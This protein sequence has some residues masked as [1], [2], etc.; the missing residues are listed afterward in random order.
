MHYGTNSGTYGLTE[1]FDHAHYLRVL[2]ARRCAGLP[3]RVKANL[4]EHSMFGRTLV[5]KKTG[6]EYVI[7]HVHEAWKNGFYF[8]ATARTVNTHSHVGLVIGNR[9]SKATDILALLDEF[10]ETFDLVN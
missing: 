10:E 2:D 7:D 4:T 9:N 1:R 5:N 3:V 8:Y 6:Q